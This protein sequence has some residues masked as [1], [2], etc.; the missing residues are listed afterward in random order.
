V[1]SDRGHGGPVVGAG[2]SQ[3]DGRQVY[4]TGYDHHGTDGTSADPGTVTVIDTVDDTV[5]SVPVGTWPSSVTFSP[6]G[7][8]A[9]VVSDRDT[10]SHR[11]TVIDRATGTSTSLT[12][13][14]Y[15]A[16]VAF[17][18]GGRYGYTTVWGAG[19]DG[20]EVVFFALAD[21]ATAVVPVAT[22][23][24][25]SLQRRRPLRL[26]AQ[27]ARRPGDGDR[28]RRGGRCGRGRRRAARLTS[29]ESSATCCAA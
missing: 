27:R 4:F 12:T 9:Y 10:A 22:P 17:S 29:T 5:W 28:P 1:T 2:R 24:R 15:A 18:P 8:Y 26:R 13:A 6:D 23:R 3:A 7:A 21:G 16:D 11:V 25:G 19:G 20:G 14:G